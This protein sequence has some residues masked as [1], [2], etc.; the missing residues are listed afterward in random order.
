[1]TQDRTARRD[2]SL[3]C[4]LLSDVSRARSDFHG[5]RNRPDRHEAKAAQTVRALRLAAA[6][7]AYAEAATSAGIPLPYRYRDQLRL[8][9]ALGTADSDLARGT[10]G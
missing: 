9:K 8:Y 1:M 2:E 3:L 5:A 10:S 4:E 6:M 7:E